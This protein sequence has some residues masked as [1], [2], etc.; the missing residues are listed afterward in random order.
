M[1]NNDIHFFLDISFIR[2]LVFISFFCF[3]YAAKSQS[4]STYSFL[5]AGHAY[6]AHTGKN[7]GLHPPFLNK[8][9][10]LGILSIHQN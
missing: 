1:S 10:E 9:I 2:F 8:I 7:L 5:V 3:A 6:G 4:D